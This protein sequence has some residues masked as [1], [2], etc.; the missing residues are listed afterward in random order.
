MKQKALA[1]MAAEDA[2]RWAAAEMFYGEGAGTRRKLLD[3]ELDQKRRQYGDTDFGGPSYGDLFVWAY[4]DLDMNKFAEAAIKERKALD[5]AAKAGQN[6]RALKSGNLNNLT[7]GVFVIVGTGYVLHATGYDKKI[8]VE[9]KKVW[10]RAK[11]EYKFRK[12][13]MEGRNVERING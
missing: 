6:F 10:R 2:K 13:R 5:R 8:A 7:T 4:Q 1:K 9:A 3:A 11:V 12:A